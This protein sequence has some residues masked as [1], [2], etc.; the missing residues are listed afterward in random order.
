MGTEN[1]TRQG[2]AQ[3]VNEQIGLS[4]NDA[5]DLVDNF[6]SC[7]KNSLL[8]GEDVKIVNFGVFKV[9][10]KASRR[11]RNPQ[12]GE[13]MEISKRRMITFGPSKILREKVND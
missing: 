4:Q 8:T 11:G 12:T 2:L 3:A 7:I 5:S 13:S 9:K 6:F 1:L 10:D